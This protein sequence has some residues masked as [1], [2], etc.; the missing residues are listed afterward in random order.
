MVLGQLFGSDQLDRVKRI[1]SF[2]R[3][4]VEAEV[5]M[6][7]SNSHSYSYGYISYNAIQ[8]F[9][10]DRICTLFLTSIALQNILSATSSVITDIFNA[11]DLEASLRGLRTRP[12]HTHTHTIIF[13]SYLFENL[14][15]FYQNSNDF[16][17]FESLFISAVKVGRY[18]ASRSSIRAEQICQCREFGTEKDRE[19]TTF[20]CSAC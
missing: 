19:L 20:C 3:K 17:S 6:A 2:Y 5:V 10:S 7:I 1:N 15:E 9:G 4:F 18:L 8:L 14:F 12:L 13:E 16:D 11:R